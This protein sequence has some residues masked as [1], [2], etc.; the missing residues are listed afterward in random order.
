MIDN[1]PADRGRARFRPEPSDDAGERHDRFLSFSA[2]MAGEG[3]GGA[4]DSGGIEA[5]ADRSAAG[6]APSRATSASTH[7]ETYTYSQIA[8]YL[9]QGYWNA[10]GRPASTPHKFFPARFG[11]TL[12]TLSVDIEELTPAGKRFARA[13]LSAWE[14][15]TGLRFV[16]TTENADIEFDDTLPGGGEAR[17]TY[18]SLGPGEEYGAIIVS[19]ID[20]ST[21]YFFRFGT[22]FDSYAMYVYIHEIGHALGLGH[23]GDYN[24]AADYE[25]DAHYRNDSWQATVM[26]YFDQR[27]NTYT[28][29]AGASY[30]WPVTPMPADIV[31][32]Q[33]LYGAPTDIRAGNTVYGYG[34]NTGGYLDGWLSWTWAVALTIYDNGGIDT[35]DLR[36]VAAD[37]RIDLRAETAGATAPTRVSDVNGLKGNLFIGPGTVIENARGG[38]G[39]DVIVGNGADNTL[40]GGGGGDSLRGRGGDDLLIGGPGN[41]TAIFPGRAAYYRVVTDGGVTTVADLRAGA[42]EG[43]DT[44]REIETIRFEGDRTV[45]TLPPAPP[46]PPAAPEGALEL[47]VGGGEDEDNVIVLGGNLEILA[48]GGGGDDYYIVLPGLSNR[49]ALADSDGANVLA[50]DDG[51]RIESARLEEDALYIELAG[52][53]T[54]EIAAEAAGAFRFAAEPVAGATLGATGFLALI[55]ENDGYTVIADAAPPE[56]EEE[57]E[58]AAEGTGR[59]FANGNPGV[60]VFAFGYD[61][62]VFSDGGRGDDIYRITRFQSRDA[63]I[64]DLSGAN[65]V[66]FDDGAAIAGFAN[67]RGAFVVELENGAVVEIEA[68]SA[69]RYRLGDGRD[70]PASEFRAWAES[71]SWPADSGSR[72]AEGTGGADLFVYRFDSAN[73]APPAAWEGDGTVD[74]ILDFNPAEGDRIRFVDTASGAGRV[75]TLAEFRAAFDFSAH[76]GGARRALDAAGAEAIAL[77]FGAPGAAGLDVYRTAALDPTLFDPATG[78]FHDAD[79]LIAAL[80][81]AG[82]LEFM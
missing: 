19:R 26:S 1:G 5:R 10:L 82:A 67:R 41:D 40:R 36:T 62:E 25:T 9:T 60:D 6:G 13:A 21:Q 42:P 17:V 68:A 32:I 66:I 81:G 56:A 52:G 33:R 61:M 37:Q 46:P 80:G 79:A 78:E 38:A 75:D 30:A 65:L 23:A 34:S 43:T 57:A 74:A 48:D 70:M 51:A 35:I 53:A 2:V 11:E 31:A 59:V 77:A 15:A 47:F 24:N 14:A 76:P 4:S 49:A 44:L 16:E 50:F 29:A 3:A 12:T 72:V 73:G 45:R 64:S 58:A 63:V 8:D 54:V 71:Q 39:D 69:N 28:R 55:E 18:T 22:G 20:I 7:D 27:E